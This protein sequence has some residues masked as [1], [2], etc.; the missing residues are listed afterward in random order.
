MFN[1]WM[2]SFFRV[3]YFAKIWNFKLICVSYF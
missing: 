3:A 1:S 2:L